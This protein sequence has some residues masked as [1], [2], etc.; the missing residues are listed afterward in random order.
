MELTSGKADVQTH[1]SCSLALKF[2]YSEPQHDPISQWLVS[3][4]NNIR[5][6]TQVMVKDQRAMRL[7]IKQELLLLISKARL[8]ASI[9]NILL[10]ISRC[11]PAAFCCQ[12]PV[13]S[14]ISSPPCV[15]LLCYF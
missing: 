10:I 1:L 2:L 5:L 4:H 11:E 9:G 13:L 7:K 12:F 3:T 14:S 15:S 8:K 6:R